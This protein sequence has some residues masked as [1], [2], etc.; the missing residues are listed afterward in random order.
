MLVSNL[1][2]MLKLNSSEESIMYTVNFRNDVQ[3]V[4]W[5]LELVGQLSDGHWEN[6]RPDDHW[7]IWALAKAQ[8]DDKN[9]GRNFYGAKTNYNFTSS[10]LLEAVGERMIVSVKLWEYCKDLE[11][12]EKLMN[13][14]SFD[15]DKFVW[16]GLPMYK[17]TYW[18]DI[19]AVLNKQ[20]LA[21]IRNFVES[22]PFD[23]KDLRAE[24]RDMKQIIKMQQNT[25]EV[26]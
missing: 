17:G 14:F 22:H 4:L 6:A 10:E 1:T 7:R 20:D 26:A 18:D 15:N 16:N 23:M 19:R 11:L 13:L 24:L 21:K 9:L 3:L 8:V 2:G 12:V 5:N 25:K